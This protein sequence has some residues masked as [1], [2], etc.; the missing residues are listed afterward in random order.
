ME[1]LHKKTCVITGAARGIG[2]AIARRFRDEG[3]I[4]ILTDIDEAAGAAA[5]AEIG[6]RFE[7]LDVR[8]EA[9]WRRLAERVPTADVVVNNAGVTG[10]EQGAA[11]HDPEQASLA[12]WREV[13]RVNLD[14]TFLGCRYAIKAMKAQGAGS[15][16]NISSRSGLVGIPLAAAYASS[17]AAIRNHSKTVALYCAQKGWKIRC[18]SIHPAAIRTRIWEPILGT[19]PDRE[20]KMQ[21]L[22]ADTPL[23]RFGMP[24]EVAAIAV[25]LASDEA[26]YVTGTEIHIDGGLLAGSAASPG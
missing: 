22:V 25:T 24:E 4:V 12:D 6:C 3:A 17:K 14:G 23:K 5:A 13:H 15:I 7:P 18:N 20:A 19:G 10:F 9:D 2:R 8:E 16:I 26:T 21:A 11:A 1:R